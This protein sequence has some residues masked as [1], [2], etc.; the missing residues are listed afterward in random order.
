VNNVM[1]WGP[2][3]ATAYS[4]VIVETLGRFFTHTWRRHGRI[5]VPRIW[6]DYA[7]GRNFLQP[8]RS[9]TSNIIS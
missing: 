2:E 1:F 8:S 6:R 5:Q 3:D 4:E 9:F 7:Q